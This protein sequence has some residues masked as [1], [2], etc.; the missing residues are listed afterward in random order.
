MKLSI[1]MPAYNERRTIREIISRVLNVDLGGLERELVIV[2]DGSTDGTRE[3]LAE[4]DGKHGVRVV[5]QL[6]NLGQGRGG[7]ARAS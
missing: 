2:D 4:Y 5:P 3:I 1:I 6:K 7:R